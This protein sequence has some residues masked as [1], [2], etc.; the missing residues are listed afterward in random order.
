M[1]FKAGYIADSI[2]KVI[3][4]FKAKLDKNVIVEQNKLLQIN[5]LLQNASS[6]EV[7]F[8]F[9]HKPNYHKLNPVL[10]TINNIITR[11]LPTRLPVSIE[12]LFSEIKLTEPN[13]D[14]FEFNFPNSIKNIDFETLFQLLHIVEP[15][16]EIEKNQYGGFLGSLSEWKFLDETLKEFPFAKQILQSQRDFSTIGTGLAGGKSLDF[17]YEFPYLNSKSIGSLSDKQRQGI[18]FEFDGP[19]HKLQTVKFYDN[20][21]DDVADDANF[22]TLRQSFDT[23]GLN[24]NI[25]NQ[26]KNEIFGIFKTNYNRK[27]KDFLPEYSLLFI[28]LAVTR[29][30]KTIIEFLI[31]NPNEFEKEEIKIAIIERDLPCGSMAI[32][33]LQE[34]FENVNAILEEADKLI[35]PK[36]DFSIFENQNWVIDN[37]LHLECVLEF[38]HFALK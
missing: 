16:L 35:L 9:E 3:T 17:S 15:K 37:K 4:D 14:E 5:G 38:K 6:F 1:Q 12:K 8:P 34:M 27:I 24:P 2:A 30:Q 21:R 26:F 32:K 23:I 19:H 36:I 10:A 25:E 28:P 31:S 33:S 29:I 13:K 18:I 22:E 20:Y 7:E 11:G